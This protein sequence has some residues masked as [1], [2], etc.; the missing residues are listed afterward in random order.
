ME[1]IDLTEVLKFIEK[2]DDCCA[3]SCIE[4]A[5]E[6]FDF[7]E[8]YREIEESEWTQDYKY[9]SNEVVFEL[10]LTNGEKRYVEMHMSRSGSPFTDWYYSVDGVNEVDKFKGNSQVSVIISGEEHEYVARLIERAVSELSED[11]EESNNVTITTNIT[12]NKG[13]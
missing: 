12:E 1:K 8:N 2:Q 7:L 3:D 9:Q 13:W 6:E 10:T 5:I 4:E 11:L